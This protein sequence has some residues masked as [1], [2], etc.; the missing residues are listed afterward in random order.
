MSTLS[1]L[2]RSCTMCSDRLLLLIL[3]FHCFKLMSRLLVCCS[4]PWPLCL[5]TTR[6][7]YS[8]TGM[9]WIKSSRVLLVSCCS[10]FEAMHY[11]QLLWCTA[12]AARMSRIWCTILATTT[13]SVLELT[14]IRPRSCKYNCHC[15]PYMKNYCNLLLYTSTAYVIL[16]LPL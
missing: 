12:L 2:W 4:L 16:S 15:L 6:C 8:L 9:W 3:R 10:A 7:K 1:N 14:Q 5:Y 13:K 11:V